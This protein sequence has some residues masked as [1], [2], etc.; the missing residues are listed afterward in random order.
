MNLNF[1]PKEPRFERP[2]VWHNYAAGSGIQF[3]SFIHVLEKSHE[4][5]LQQITKTT[6]HKSYKI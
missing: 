3:I 5:Q 6:V 2:A 4:G 1:E